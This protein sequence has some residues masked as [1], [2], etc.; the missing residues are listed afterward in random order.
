MMEICRRRDEL[1]ERHVKV[2]R[3][4]YKHIGGA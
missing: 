1:F 4:Y 3:E 2:L